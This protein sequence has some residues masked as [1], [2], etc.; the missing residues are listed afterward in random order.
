MDFSSG[1]LTNSRSTRRSSEIEAKGV[2]L[3]GISVDHGFAHRAFQEKLGID[4]PLL[5]TSSQGRGRPRLR[6]LYREGRA[7]PNSSLF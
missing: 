5:A 6:R 3:V 7:T 2:E 1:A 4:T